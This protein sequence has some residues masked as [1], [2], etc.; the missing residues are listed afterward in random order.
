MLEDI[1]GDIKNNDKGLKNNFIYN[2]SALLEI[3]EVE[4][5]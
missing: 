3:I 4:S 2:L 1:Y 5:P